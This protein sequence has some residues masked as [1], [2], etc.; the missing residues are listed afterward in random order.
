MR[1]VH[2]VRLSATGTDRGDIVLSWLSKIVAV[3]ALFGI[4]FFDA[5]SV[6]STAMN[7]SDQA[8]YAAREASER[9]QETRSVQEAYEHAVEAAIEQNPLNVVDPKS[10]RIDADNTVHL[11]VSRTATTLVLF[12]WDRTAKWAVVERDAVGRSVA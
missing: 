12:R 8:S 10:F 5:I 2:P 1:L 3:L 6:G 7:V 11:R 4:V 9:W